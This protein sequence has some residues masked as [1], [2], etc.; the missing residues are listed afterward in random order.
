M[1]F[2]S[3]T[4]EAKTEIAR[5]FSELGNY[6]EP[7]VP[8]LRVH[9]A[10]GGVDNRRG[11]QGEAIWEQAEASHWSA[12]VAAWTDTPESRIVDN[13]VLVQDFRVFLDAR[14]RAAAGIFAIKLV[15]GE[16]L[17]QLEAP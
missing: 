5:L 11:A 6:E 17:V 1:A 8:I 3:I 14:A 7:T 15:A 12:D 4:A 2:I 9:W 13:T 10:S 16:L